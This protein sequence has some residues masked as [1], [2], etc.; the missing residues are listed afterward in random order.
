MGKAIGCTSL[1]LLV[2]F[3]IVF[4]L[5]LAFGPVVFQFVLPICATLVSGYIVLAIAGKV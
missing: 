4:F 3:V 2:V 5:S 1:I